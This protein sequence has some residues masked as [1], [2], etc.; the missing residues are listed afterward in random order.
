M[1]DAGKAKTHLLVALLF[2]CHNVAMVTSAKRPSIKFLLMSGL[3]ISRR[4]DRLVTPEANIYKRHDSLHDRKCCFL[5]YFQGSNNEGC[6]LIGYDAV[7]LK[8]EPTS[9]NTETIRFSETP[10]HTRAT[11]N[12]IPHKTKSM[13]TTTSLVILGRLLTIQTKWPRMVGRV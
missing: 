1:I 13:I 6:C 11:R 3:D 10:V 5:V 7:W 4:T 9:R 8:Y 2:S 12:H